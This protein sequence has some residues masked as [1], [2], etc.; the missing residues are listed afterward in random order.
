MMHG[1][2]QNGLA[3]IQIV[4]DRAQEAAARQIKRQMDLAP[5]FL[6]ELDG[7]DAPSG[8]DSDWHTRVNDLKRLAVLGRE[9]RP[10]NFVAGDDRIQALLESV[11]IQISTQR[12]RY[13]DMISRI[14]R[15]ERNVEPESP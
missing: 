2:Q 8:A 3:V 14:G 5:Y 13:R 12:E 11:P 15:I 1:H 7:R 6:V 10:Q 4:D 9:G